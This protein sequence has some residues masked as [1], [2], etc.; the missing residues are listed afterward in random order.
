MAFV[1]IVYQI[2]TEIKLKRNETEDEKRFNKYHQCCEIVHA[3][4][5]SID[6]SWSQLQTSVDKAHTGPVFPDNW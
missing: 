1:S 3:K 4:A 6:L 2:K 5:N